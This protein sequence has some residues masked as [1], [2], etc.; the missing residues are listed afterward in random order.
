MAT[1][2]FCRGDDFADEEGA[3]RLVVKGLD[4]EKSYLPAACLTGLTACRGEVCGP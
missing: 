2:Q 4:F 1:Y 3:L